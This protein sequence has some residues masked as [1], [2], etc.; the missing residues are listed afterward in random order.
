[1]SELVAAQVPS[2]AASA[3][4]GRASLDGDSSGEA[5]TLTEAMKVTLG[6]DSSTDTSSCR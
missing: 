6:G 5:V 3:L 4:G 1:M 2:A